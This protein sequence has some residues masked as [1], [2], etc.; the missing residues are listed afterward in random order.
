MVDATEIWRRNMHR[1][2]IRG[3]GGWQKAYIGH[4]SAIHKLWSIAEEQYPLLS[5]WSFLLQLPSWCSGQS[6]LP[7]LQCYYSLQALGSEASYVC[8][9]QLNSHSHY[10]YIN[11]ITLFQ[12]MGKFRICLFFLSF[13][14]YI[15]YTFGDGVAWYIMKRGATSDG[16]RVVINY[17]SSFYHFSFISWCFY[18]RFKVNCLSIFQ[19][20]TLLLYLACNLASKF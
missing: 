3:V 11:K 20:N 18:I 17:L 13:I 19:F 10:I 8:S 14:Q 5:S 1:W 15:V 6:L 2:G 7:G 12:P 4:G 16:R 9:T